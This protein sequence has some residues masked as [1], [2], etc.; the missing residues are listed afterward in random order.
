MTDAATVRPPREGEIRVFLADDHAAARAVVRSLLEEGGDIRVIGEAGD[1]HAAL[2]EID[3]CRPDVAILDLDMPGLDGL[4]LA[5]TLRERRVPVRLI[6]LT[7]HRSKAL[8]ARAFASGIDG[9]V[10]KDAA[11]VELV[12]SVRAVHDGQMYVS[13]PYSGEFGPV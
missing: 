8:V 4:A 3:A 10:A 11:L 7:V 6:L 12:A 9:Y 1:G 5:Q 2:A 13:E